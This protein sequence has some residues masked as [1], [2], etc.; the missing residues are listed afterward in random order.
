MHIGD[1]CL[2]QLPIYFETTIVWATLR[3][4]VHQG[5]NYQAV[6]GHPIEE[7]HDQHFSGHLPMLGLNE[8]MCNILDTNFH[9]A[10]WNC[11]RYVVV[12][13]SVGRRP[14]L[15]NAKSQW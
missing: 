6:T 12:R 15:I 8:Y 4:A 1:H 2:T 5:G 14:R 3:E 11:S 10:S 9:L 7:N 13:L